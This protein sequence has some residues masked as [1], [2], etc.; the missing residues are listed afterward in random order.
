M[1]TIVEF[2]SNGY[3]RIQTCCSIICTLR[4]CSKLFW[5]NWA[6][7]SHDLVFNNVAIMCSQGRTQR[8]AALLSALLVELT[9][10]QGTN[11]MEAS[12]ICCL[13]YCIRQ[14]SVYKQ[15]NGVWSHLLSWRSCMSGFPES[16][17]VQLFSEAMKSTPLVN[18]GE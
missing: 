5:H 7:P 12:S 14:L 3:Y 6:R 18:F 4:L 1:P 2:A 9:G 11:N 13:T 10:I 8:Y 17:V 16:T 15:I